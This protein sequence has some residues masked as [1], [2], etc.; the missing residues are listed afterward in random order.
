MGSEEGKEMGGKGR[1]RREGTCAATTGVCHFER[2]GLGDR[3]VG[4]WRGGERGRRT[5]LS[6]LYEVCQTRIPRL[7]LQSCRAESTK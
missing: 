4:A 2:G 5:I 7:K 1:E 3:D 6:C